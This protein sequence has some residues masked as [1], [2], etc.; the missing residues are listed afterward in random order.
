MRLI[1]GRV[2]NVQGMRSFVFE[3]LVIVL[4]VL[5]A[6]GAQEMVDDWNWNR[7]V[8]AGELKL[9]EEHELHFKFFAEFATVAPCVE[10][11]IQRLKAH[12][13]ARG[14]STVPAPWIDDPQQPGVLRA[15]WRPISDSAW[16]A[17]QSE[18]GLMHYDAERVKEARF[19]YT[20]LRH[21][22]ARQEELRLN[23]QK[24]R[25]LADPIA[26]DPRSRV[27]LLQTLTVMGGQLDDAKLVGRQL[28]V[29]IA[30]LGNLPDSLD[31]KVSGTTTYCRAQNLPLGDWKAQLALGL[32][33][34]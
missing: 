34:F 18:G 10:A 13:L 1:R 6:L 2:R 32:R 24:L 17:V 14:T 23:S 5:I 30:R 11:Q 16:Q 21:Y 8:A 9:K 31:L 27:D 20:T 3:V 22:I 12:I 15:P 19:Y 7:R 26:L 28:M 33:D 29:T 4:G 25:I